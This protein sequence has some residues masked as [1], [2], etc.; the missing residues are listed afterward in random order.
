MVHRAT[1]QRTTR[2]RGCSPPHGPYA[3]PVTGMPFV[4]ELA[5]RLRLDGGSVEIDYGPRKTAE[6]RCAEAGDGPRFTLATSEA[7]LGAAVV[8]L[9]RD[10]RDALWPD[11]TIEQA[12]FNLLLVHLHEVVSGRDLAEPLR[13]AAEGVQRL[14]PRRPGRA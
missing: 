6:L 12:G 11:S 2:T 13:I 10:C 14:S 3:E 7:E 5:R 8:A 1:V 4:D 9:G